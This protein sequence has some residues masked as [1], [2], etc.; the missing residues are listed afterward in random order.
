MAPAVL[1]HWYQFPA[2][3]PGWHTAI[4]VMYIIIGVLATTGNSVALCMFTTI[5][6]L[7]TRSNHLMTSLAISDLG[8]TLTQVPLLVANSFS[9]RWVAPT[10]ACQVY[11]FCGGLFGTASIMSLAMIASERRSVLGKV[12]DC[13]L[14]LRVT[15][16]RIIF[17][18]VFSAIWMSL[19]FFGVS[20]FVTEGFMTSC[21]FDYISTDIVTRVYIGL[22][23]VLCYVVPLFVIIRC[24][25]GI[26]KMLSQL[27]EIA[28]HTKFG[29]PIKTIRESLLRKK[30]TQLTRTIMILV[31]AWCLSWTPY[32]VVVIL[33]MTGSR[34]LTPFVS[35]SCAIFA[36]TSAVYNPFIYGLAHQKF[37]KALKK[38]FGSWSK[39]WTPARTSSNSVRTRDSS[40][41]EL[42]VMRRSSVTIRRGRLCQN[43]SPAVSG[44][45]PARPI[46][47]K[48][49]EIFF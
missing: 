28:V 6:S 18:W 3:Q 1:P 26:Y 4:G 12:P 2:P 38:K 36:K 43:C 44:A 14:G 10:W 41:L 21:T 46:Y 37:R 35:V 49:A 32:T 23:I 22:S 27:P 17:V 16:P 25:C 9:H 13:A 15:G 7:R 24:Y 34:R 33:G 5:A 29:L 19:P 30:E 47:A 45:G 42:R 8:M 20:R 31:V 39:A 48:N 11:G 40:G